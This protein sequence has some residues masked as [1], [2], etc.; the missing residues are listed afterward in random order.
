[1]R[2]GDVV[3]PKAPIEGAEHHPSVDRQTTFAMEPEKLG[4][5]KRAQVEAH[6]EQCESCRQG[7]ER[8]RSDPHMKAWWEAGCPE[9]ED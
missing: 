7:V 1:M 4:A 3:L 8:M 9:D 2:D 6:L 5:P